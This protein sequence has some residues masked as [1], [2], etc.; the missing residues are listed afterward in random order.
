M[1]QPLIVSAVRVQV[2][3]LYGNVT[4]NFDLALLAQI[5]LN[6]V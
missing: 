5:Y 4:L 1:D 2:P 3:S 6:Q